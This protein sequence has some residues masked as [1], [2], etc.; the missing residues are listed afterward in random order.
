MKRT[1]SICI[2]L[3]TVGQV[4]AQNQSRRAQRMEERLSEIQDTLRF[5]RLAESKKNLEF[6]EDKLLKVNALAD[7]LEAKR[8]EVR[9]EEG[10]LNRQIRQAYDGGGDETAA[11]D[12]LMQL[13]AEQMA[14]EQAFW[15]DIKDVLTPQEATRFFIFYEKFQKEVQR[16]VRSLQQERMQQRRNKRQP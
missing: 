12:Q 2:L 4:M 1:I 16:R 6:S 5:I 14:A 15:S 11:I 7:V 9:R 10:R 8:F 3:L 13:R